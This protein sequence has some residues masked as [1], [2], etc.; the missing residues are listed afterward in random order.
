MYSLEDL[1]RERP[2]NRKRVDNLKKRMLAGVRAHALRELRE[3]QQMTQVQLA[4]AL[5][6][7]Q[8]RVSRFENGDLEK[9]QIDTLR[10]YIEA[11]GGELHVVAV[12]G[13]KSIPLA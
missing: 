1:Q 9:T 6:V 2:A 4:H 5:Q 12:V 7:S 13:E 10:R 3:T 8:N 11:L